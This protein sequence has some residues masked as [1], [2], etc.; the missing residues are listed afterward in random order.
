MAEKE[1]Q[2]VAENNY[3]EREKGQIPSCENERGQP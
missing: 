3:T 2:N 1:W